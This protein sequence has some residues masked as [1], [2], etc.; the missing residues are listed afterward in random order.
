MDTITSRACSRVAGSHSRCPRLGRALI[1]GAAVVLLLLVAAAP[2]S[3]KKT[4]LSV[5]SGAMTGYLNQYDANGFAT[6]AHLGDSG[7]YKT[8]LAKCSFTFDTDLF[9]TDDPPPDI[10]YGP[11]ANTMVLMK[12][13]LKASGGALKAWGAD[14]W[15]AV[16]HALESD[17][18]DKLTEEERLRFERHT[19]YMTAVAEQALPLLVQL[20]SRTRAA[21]SVEDLRG[22]WGQFLAKMDAAAQLEAPK[23]YP[24]DATELKSWF[25]FTVDPAAIKT[26]YLTAPAFSGAVWTNLRT[27]LADPAPDPTPVELWNTWNKAGVGNGGTSPTVTLTRSYTI[28][29]VDTYHWNDQKGMPSP[30]TIA[31]RAADGKLYGPWQATGTPGMFGVPNANWT[32]TPNV[33]VP[34]GSYTIVDSD[35]STWSQNAGSGGKGF[36]SGKGVP[37]GGTP[38]PS[39][40]PTPTTSPS[41]SPS[42]TQGPVVLL[43]EDFEDG[44]TGWTV[45]TAVAGRPTWASTT[46]RAALGQRSVYCSG[47]AIPAPGPYADDMN[48]WLVKGPF[49]LSCYA[50]ATLTFTLFCDTQKNADKVCWYAST[51]NQH[52]YGIEMSGTATDWLDETFDLT[53]VPVLG[54]VCGKK[55]VWIAFNFRSDASVTREGAYVDEVELVAER[56][57][58]LTHVPDIDVAGLVSRVRTATFGGARPAP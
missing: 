46:Q 56:S 17:H 27:A 34:A 55:Q 43:S 25:G 36:T 24:P 40:S 2:A 15:R 33:T 13:P 29:M 31:L 53:T 47:S 39:P 57:A 7:L 16:T 38:T 1:A 12:S 44:T 58:S 4:Y 35:P 5:S 22:I 19:A 52:Y 18:G 11:K 30:G 10:S 42:P 41:P 54:N 8:R 21:G 9:A 50:G 14:T 32:V 6:V 20:E 37:A 45:G 28:T 26:A 49:D 3:A 51:D 48:A 23:K